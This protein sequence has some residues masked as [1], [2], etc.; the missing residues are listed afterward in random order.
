MVCIT[1]P[2]GKVSFEPLAAP[3]ANLAFVTAFAAIESA[4]IIPPLPRPPTAS[5][6]ILPSQLIVTGIRLF[7]RQYLYDSPNTT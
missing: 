2:V 1:E 5:P 4:S 7:P 3:S 6:V